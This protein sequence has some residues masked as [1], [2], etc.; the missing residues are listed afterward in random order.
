MESSILGNYDRNILSDNIRNNKLITA[1]MA[2]FPSRSYI[3]EDT[4]NS[5]YNQVD[6]IRIYLNE[7]K[8]IPNFCKRP[9][10]ISILGDNLEASGKFYWATNK[11]EYYFTIDDD[12]I[13]SD[14]YVYNMISAIQRFNDSVII[15]MHGG[16]LKDKN[17]I[18]TY[19]RNP[20]NKEGGAFQVAY[21]FGH[22]EKNDTFIQILGTGVSLF[23]T[24][25]FPIDCR[26]FLYTDSNDIEV[27]ILAQK[28]KT[29][30]LM[31]NHKANYLKTNPKFRNYKD[32]LYTRHLNN[33][34]QSIKLIKSIDWELYKYDIK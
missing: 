34:N 8:E 24:N 2:T 10:I 9:K 20:V 16:I 17:M 15:T 25:A 3:V 12:I 30:I 33:Q 29:P 19:Y 26:E 32:C 4:I 11:N 18:N 1:N 13:Y 28:R 23:N 22:F 31:L 14:D 5:I 27:S 7:Y 6:V 21:N